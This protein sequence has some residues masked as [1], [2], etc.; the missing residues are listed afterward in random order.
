MFGFGIIITLMILSTAYVLY[1]LITISHA[2]KVTLTSDVRSI[3]YAKQLQTLLY[4]QERNTQKYFISHDRTYHD[5]FLEGEERFYENIDSLL[6]VESNPEE[7]RLIDRVLQT[8]GWLATIHFPNAE[9][10]A[11]DPDSEIN[12]L[13]RADSLELLHATITTLIRMNQSSID[14]SMEYVEETITRSS[15]V[16]L[17]ITLCTLLAALTLAFII[18][19]TITKPIHT[20]IKGTEQIARGSFEPIRISSRDEIALLA[21]AMNDMSAKLKKIN[22]YKADLM[23]QMMHEFRTPLQ[24]ILSALYIMKEQSSAPLNS[25]QVLMLD[26]IRS[27]VD[28]LTS[29]T[30]QLLDLAKLDAGKMEYRLQPTDL[31]DVITPAIVDA[32]LIALEKNITITLDARPVP[33]I[34]ADGEKIFFIINNLLNNAIKYTNSGGTINVS[35]THRGKSIKLSVEDT[36]VGILPEDL[37]K[38]F[39]KFYQ[40]TNVEKLSIKG[41]GLGLA[42]VKAFTEG[43]GGTV[44]VAST[45][46]VGTTFTIELPV[47][48]GEVLRRYEQ[49]LTTGKMEFS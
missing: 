14:N 42:L 12:Q 2:A 33:P 28:R 40:A 32:R 24:T 21:S 3:D 46:N 38:V 7:M 15:N 31:I 43:H 27:S 4:E 34:L 48:A 10:T 17:G 16:A 18:P 13:N 8:H 1:Q 26:S 37:P 23:Q 20:L 11:A 49:Q 39:V 47:M 25:E 35:V 30:N 5:L 19:R 41:T 22:E 29:F 9:H 44:R 6:M 45:V 36:G